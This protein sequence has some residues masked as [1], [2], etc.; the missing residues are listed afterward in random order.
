M[1]KYNPKTIESKWQKE[2][3]E[4]DIVKIDKDDSS[5]EKYY[6]LDMFPYPSSDGLHMGHTENYTIS[7]IVYRYK[8]MKGFS[9]LHPQGF[10]SF[11]L[12]A[13]N[14]AIKT[15]VHPK[16]TTKKNIENYIKQMQ[17]LGLGY[18]FDEKIITSS[19]EYYK[20]T[21]WIFTK[22]FEAGLAYRKTDTINWC[23]SCKTGL[24]N[25]QVVGGLCERCKNEV[26]QKEVPGWF[27]KITDFADELIDGLE[28]LDWPE[29]TKKNQTNWIGKSEG[30]EIEFKIKGVDRK[31]T[32]FTTRPDTLFGATYCVFA[33][34][35]ALVGE[36]KE[37]IE[38]WS[39]VE[40]Y[41]NDTKKKTER[42]R[43]EGKEKTREDRG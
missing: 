14:Y 33:P 28:N 35:H 19:P 12:P 41:V 42:E 7:D 27:F 26:I 18:D 25:E 4:Q 15:G 11:G 6:V 2:W 20:W 10:D 1:K 30:A 37:Q 36:M 24:A 34:E 22:F 21:Q 8:R 13:E 43:L 38:N 3:K 32:V 5:K 29:H 31:F 17:T 40:K 39:E 23:E 9:V 16:E